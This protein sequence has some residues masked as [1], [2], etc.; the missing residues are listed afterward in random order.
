MCVEKKK[1]KGRGEED[2]REVEKGKAKDSMRGKWGEQGEGG[3]REERGEYT[4][5]K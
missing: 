2:E 3:K 4:R 1:K 5:A